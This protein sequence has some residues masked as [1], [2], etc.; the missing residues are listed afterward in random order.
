LIFF[1][2]KKR[3]GKKGGES[4]RERRRRRGGGRDGVPL[5]FY[6][7]KLFVVFQSLNNNLLL[8]AGC[9][10]AISHGF[11]IAST[12]TTAMMMRV[13]SA[14]HISLRVLFC[15]R[16]ASTRC[17]TPDSTWSRARPTCA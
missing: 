14:Q 8:P 3:K 4:V 17:V 7:Q 1:V 9:L 12:I 13:Q 10:L 11:R 5:S 16:F 6:I 15:D 2:Q